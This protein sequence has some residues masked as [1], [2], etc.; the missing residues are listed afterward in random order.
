MVNL[1]GTD[2]AILGVIL[3]GAGII[4]RFGK[5]QGTVDEWKKSI[6][7]K[8]EEINQMIRINGKMIRINGKM[9]H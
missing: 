3:T 6:D 1:S 9:E 7:S 4:Y 5:W 2:I 8:Y